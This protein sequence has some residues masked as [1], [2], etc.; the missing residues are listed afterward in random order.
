MLELKNVTKSYGSR[1]LLFQ[2]LKGVSLTV[3]KGEFVGIM[4][5]SGSGKSTLLNLIGTIDKPTTGQVLLDGEN[6][7]ELNQDDLAKFRRN[8]LGFVFQGFNLMPTLTVGENIVLPLTLDG[9]NVE[10]MTNA[11]NDMAQILGIEQLLDKRISQISGGQAQRVAIARAMIHEP[12]LLLADEPTGN[13]DTKASKEVM[14][15]LSNLN[16]RLHSTILMVTHDAFAASY[17]QKIM[18]IKDG[19]LI[20]E[21]Q[22][23]ASQSEFYDDIL[24]CLK[25]LD[26]EAD[27]F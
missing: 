17:C 2:A 27:D 23:H 20:Q 1:D 21:I 19:E 15:L 7:S 3:D 5:P 11:L 14:R 18:F 6:P 12:K 13:L 8:E 24:V 26:G 16:Q 25:Q 22:R 10:L 4:G 9:E